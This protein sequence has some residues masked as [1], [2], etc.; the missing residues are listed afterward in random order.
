MSAYNS[1]VSN[2]HGLLSTRH[3]NVYPNR[4]DGIPAISDY[5]T[6]TEIL[7][8]E[9]GYKYFVISDAGATDR[10]CNAFNLCRSSPIDMEAVTLQALPAG[11]DVEMGGGSLCVTC[12]S[13][14]CTKKHVTNNPTV[15]SRRSPSW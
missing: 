6:L 7:R 2:H 11:N 12:M 13:V 8:E 9:W 10:L 4:Y 3:A 14:L 5:H 15:T 1:W